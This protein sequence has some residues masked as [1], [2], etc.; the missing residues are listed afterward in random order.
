MCLRLE[1]LSGIDVWA[2][3]MLGRFVS[4]QGLRR[5]EGA[6]S[7]L[8][9]RLRAHVPC[10]PPHCCGV[11]HAH[12]PLITPHPTFPTP[13]LLQSQSQTPQP[14]FQT[15]PNLAPAGLPSAFRRYAHMPAKLDYSVSPNRPQAF[16]P[17]YY[18]CLRIH[19]WPSTAY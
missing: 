18:L 4:C 12:C 3:S 15:F 19:F 5:V 10:S 6:A 7:R 9:P 13:S 1:V 14:G 8:T 16:Y 2:C 17:E 11:K